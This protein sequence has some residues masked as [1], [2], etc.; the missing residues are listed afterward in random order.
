MTCPVVDQNSL[1]N[2]PKTYIKKEKLKV[3]K[4]LDLKRLVDYYNSLDTL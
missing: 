3:E 2:L 1:H 4:L